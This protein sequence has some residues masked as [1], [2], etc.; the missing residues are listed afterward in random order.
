M[1]PKRVACQQNLQELP[2]EWMIVG[3]QSNGKASKEKVFEQIENHVADP[4]DLSRIF[5]N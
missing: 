3:Q 2:I 5:L 4:N 1:T